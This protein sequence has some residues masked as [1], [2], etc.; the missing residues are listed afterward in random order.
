MKDSQYG[1][2]RGVRRSAEGVHSCAPWLIAT[3]F[4]GLSNLC[5]DERGE[6]TMIFNREP[7]VEMAIKSLILSQHC[8]ASPHLRTLPLSSLTF[9]L[10]L[11]P[12]KSEHSKS[13]FD[14][15][16]YAEFDAAREDGSKE[17]RLE[18]K[19]TGMAQAVYSL[20]EN[21]RSLELDLKCLKC[22]KSRKKA[23]RK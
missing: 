17:A 8:A 2:L 15:E 4:T 6:V 5:F 14:Y 9:S 22:V 7:R 19:I 11:R 16:L 3:K 10:K 21:S 13:C 20:R 18:E 1:W 23:T 12:G